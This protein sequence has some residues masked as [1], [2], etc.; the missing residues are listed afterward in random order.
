MGSN[1]DAVSATWVWGGTEVQPRE[2]GPDLCHPLSTKG[3][4][5]L[6]ASD[7]L[8]PF[9]SMVKI[10]LGRLHNRPSWEGGEACW[11]SKSVRN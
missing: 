8:V 1:P 10:Q 4:S 3:L 2:A 7:S 9:G 5:A 11:R 6:R